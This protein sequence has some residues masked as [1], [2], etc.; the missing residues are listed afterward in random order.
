M[1]KTFAP[2]LALALC[3][4][5]ATSTVE[6]R[7]KERPAAYDALPDEQKSLVSEGQIRIGMGTDAVFIAWGKPS[8]ILESESDQGHFVTWVYHGSALRET[9]YWS[10]REVPRRGTVFLERYLETDY[11]PLSYVSAEIIFQEGVV[12]RWRT[13]PRPVD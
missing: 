1:T 2:L 9:R 3:A 7:I 8:Q 4:G 10:Y 6:S 13:L 12:K 5:C 11:I